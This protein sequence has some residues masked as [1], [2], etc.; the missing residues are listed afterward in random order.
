MYLLCN[1]YY[2]LFLV[3]PRD[4]LVAVLDPANYKENKFMEFLVMLNLING[5][6]TTNF[7]DVSPENVLLK[8]IS[9]SQFFEQIPD[10]PVIANRFDKNTILNVCADLCHF[11][12]R[13]CCN[14]LGGILR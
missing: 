3:Y 14:W 4:H 13:N 2:I 10:I 1:D 11:L 8:R 7:D 9:L 6:Y 12:H 5:R